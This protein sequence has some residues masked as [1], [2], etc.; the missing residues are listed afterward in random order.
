MA[1]NQAALIE[2]I[3]DLTIIV[4]HADSL[5]SRAEGHVRVLRSSRMPHHTRYEAER[6][7][8]RLHTIA[9]RLATAVH[10]ESPTLAEMG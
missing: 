9:A 10:D 3:C 1:T 8:A 7:A 2:N 5:V 4:S 6:I